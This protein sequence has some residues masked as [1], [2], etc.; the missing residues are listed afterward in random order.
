MLLLSGCSHPRI[1]PVV[2]PACW[3]HRLLP[4]G[5]SNPQPR[6]SN[7][8]HWLLFTWLLALCML[9]RD[10]AKL[11]LPPPAA[12]THRLLPLGCSHPSLPPAA[13]PISC[14]HWLLLPPPA[15]YLMAAPTSYSHHLLLPR[16]CSRLLLPPPAKAFQTCSSLTLPPA[17][18]PTYCS[19]LLLK[20]GH[21]FPCTRRT[22]RCQY[23]YNL[24]RLCFCIVVL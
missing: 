10:C 13:A 8:S 24:Q 11:L 20:K 21:M 6:G 12:P 16:G 14:S 2:A 3:S 15:T 23:V 19:H 9:P 1:P 7:C 4:R 18:V 5:C 17:A 22:K